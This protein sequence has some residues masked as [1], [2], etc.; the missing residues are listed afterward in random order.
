MRRGNRGQLQATETTRFTQ[1][2]TSAA[3]RGTFVDAEE[4]AMRRALAR[5]SGDDPAH[6]VGMEYTNQNRRKMAAATLKKQE[7]GEI[8]ILPKEEHEANRRARYSSI[9]ERAIEV[10]R[11]GLPARRRAAPPVAYI[12]HRRGHE[13]IRH[14]NNNF[15]RD[16]LPMYRPT[17]SS[18]ERKDELAARNQFHGK[19]PEEI[20]QMQPNPPPR[21]RPVAAAG[22]S[23][24]DEIAQL[25]AQIGDELVERQEFLDN[26]RTLNCADKHEAEVTTQIKERL[27]E[28]HRLEALEQQAAPT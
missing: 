17:P 24:T 25:K 8:P 27:N 15:E 3:L 13:E 12:P 23:V 9:S 21:R 28:L 16:P 20:L 5:I 22:G 11:V 4:A 2:S 26:L 7:R 6:R 10:P 14:A 19:S 18:D 1:P